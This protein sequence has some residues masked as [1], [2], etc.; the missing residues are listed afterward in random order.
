MK[1][2]PVVVSALFISSIF[3]SCKTDDTTAKADAMVFSGYVDSVNNVKPVY[4]ETQWKIIDDGYQLRN[5][6]VEKSLTKL[7]EAE[8]AK[9]EADRKRYAELKAKYDAQ[10]KENEKAEAT[11]RAVRNELLGTAY[12]GSDWAF[13]TSANV[14]SVYKN[15]VDRVRD[16]G[17]NYTDAQWVETRALWQALNERKEAINGNISVLDKI[18]IDHLKVAY[19]AVKAV[20]KPVS[21]LKDK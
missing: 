6:K 7:D 3:A 21:Q 1:N 8:K 18:T 15:F 4:T 5:E 9:V 11:R 13:V 19:L 14:V 12:N 10:L 2:L 17:D 16:H 20:N